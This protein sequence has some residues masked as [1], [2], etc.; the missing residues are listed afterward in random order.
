M[1][2]F[3]YDRQRKGEVKVDD[4]RRLLA[5][6]DFRREVDSHKLELLENRAAEAGN[7]NVK[8]QEFVNIVSCIG[9]LYT[10]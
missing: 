10:P 9:I 1:S 2:S 8:Y 3:Q 4:F 6:P 7:P 5:D